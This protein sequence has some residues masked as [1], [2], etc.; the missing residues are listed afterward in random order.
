MT[1]DKVARDSK[2]KEEL[3]PIVSIVKFSLLSEDMLCDYAWVQQSDLNLE[4][5]VMAC[6]PGAWESR[7]LS[8]H[9]DQQTAIKVCNEIREL[10]RAIPL[11]D[12]EKKEGA[13]QELIRSLPNENDARKR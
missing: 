10:A 11:K 7:C 5:L 6:P 9:K 8:V 13:F 12:W 1:Y 2:A 4:W 3:F